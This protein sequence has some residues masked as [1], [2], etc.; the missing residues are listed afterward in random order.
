MFVKFPEVSIA[1]EALANRSPEYPTRQTSTSRSNKKCLS[2]FIQ[3]VVVL[4]ISSQ[5]KMSFWYLLDI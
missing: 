2:V 4:L 1:N 5:I 3:Q